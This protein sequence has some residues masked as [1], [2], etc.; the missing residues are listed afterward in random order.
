[1]L[2]PE[3]RGP[4]AAWAYEARDL[5]ELSPEQ[6]VLMLPP[7][8]PNKPYDP[9]TIRK[10]E[11]ND[12]HMSRPIWR[13]LTGIYPRVAHEKGITIPFPPGESSAGTGGDTSTVPAA[14]LEQL[15]AKLDRQT[16]ALNALAAQ[17]ERLVDAQVVPKAT[18][19]LVSQA[20]AGALRVTLPD[21]LRAAGIPPK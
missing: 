4:R 3:E 21:I 8:R 15:A 7:P 20:V 16:E 9:A 11:T 14:Y 2:T 18:A 13:A 12:R 19:H 1:M 5:L 6:V 17:V 10:A